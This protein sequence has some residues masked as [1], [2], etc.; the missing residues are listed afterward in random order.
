MGFTVKITDK[1]SRYYGMT[2]DLI[3]HNDTSAIVEIP[4]GD[5]PDNLTIHT[6]LIN[7]DY[8]EMTDELKEELASYIEDMVEDRKQME[9]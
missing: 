4:V 8:V 6:V 3:I 9:E 1:E 7:N 5:S 2:G